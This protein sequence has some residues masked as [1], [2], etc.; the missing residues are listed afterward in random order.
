MFTTDIG[1]NYV[2][3]EDGGD[4]L[5]GICDV[6]NIKILNDSLYEVKAG[7]VLW[8]DLYD[9]TKTLTGGPYYHYLSVRNNKLVELPNHRYFGF[10]KYVKMDDSYLNGCYRLLI[11]KVYKNSKPTTVDHVT[12]DLLRYM[13]NEIYADYGYQFKDKRWQQIF[14][15]MPA[16]G[17]DAD[18]QKPKEGNVSVDDSLTDID[19]YNINWIAQ[20]LKGIKTNTLAKK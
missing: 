7:A 11:G 8:A 3:E 2:R 17:Y 13:K 18:T 9:S 20:K 12:P 1:T 14:E 4:S 19:K 16:Y 10:T 15:D 6:N 5:D